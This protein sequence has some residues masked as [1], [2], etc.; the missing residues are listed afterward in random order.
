MRI[1]IVGDGKVGSALTTQLSKEGHEIVI[2]DN[3]SD[4]LK[5]ASNHLDV[6][7]IKGNGANLQ[8]L[9]EADADKSDLII[10]A[11]SADE[12]N[13][14]CCLVAKKLGCKHT[15]ARVR[16]PEYASQLLFMKNELGLSMSVNPE[17]EAAREINRILAYPSALKLDSFLRGQIELIEIKLNGQNPLVNMKLSEL[18]NHFKVKVLVCA[19]KRDGEIIIPNGDVALKEGDKITITGSMSSIT[20]FF[21]EIG[22]IKKRI[23]TV[24]IVGGGKICYYLAKRLIDNGM[25]VTIIE[26]DHERCKLLCDSLPK[27]IIIEGDG[28]DRELLLEEGL[29]QTDAFVSLTDMD[30]ENVILSMYAMHSDVG[31]VITKVNRM[32]Y[33]E[34]LEK[35]GIDTV[36][37]PK[38]ITA[39]K[40]I[41]YVRAM[42]N[43]ENSTLESLYKIVDNQVE[44]LE[45]SV[46]QNCKHLHK[47]I[48]DLSFKPNLLLASIYRN[49]CVIH[50]TGN[51]TLEPNDHIIVVTTQDGLSGIEDIFDK[52]TNYEL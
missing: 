47:P 15:I 18:P 9:K 25:H 45:F 16:N 26:K 30:E 36:I 41:R 23:K 13:I 31:K 52:G 4:V 20:T 3:R 14:L 38:Y 11:T 34:I 44:A 7:G 42:V 35:M 39:A 29:A 50:P 37:S 21:K 5:A 17:L 43:A 1:I 8:V 48:K 49:N 2:I 32:P 40:I 33:F 51:D 6:I 22:I 28:S 12:V 27:A 46:P 10:A 24:M 19:I